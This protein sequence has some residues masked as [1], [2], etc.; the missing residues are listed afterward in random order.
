MSRKEKILKRLKSKPKD[1]TY[2]E[3][4]TLLLQLGFEEDKK[5]KTSGSR[6]LFRN[7]KENISIEL[8]KPHPSN[9]L[10]SYQ[11]NIL[12]KNLKKWSDWNE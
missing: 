7:I 8:H 3:A 5:G 4:K 11:I 6:V 12:L 9:V 2:E 1:F 10:K